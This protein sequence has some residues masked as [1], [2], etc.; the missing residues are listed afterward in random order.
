MTVDMPLCRRCGVLGKLTGEWWPCE[1]PDWPDLA[2]LRNG[3]GHQYAAIW[4]GAHRREDAFLVVAV[5]PERV[6]ALQAG[7]LPVRDAF[8]LPESGE[9]WL[10]HATDG[11]SGPRPSELDVNRLPPAA[12]CLALESP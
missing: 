5:S 3:A 4:Y 1:D 10:S 2:I 7:Q 8:L 6:R 9:V 11:W 12:L